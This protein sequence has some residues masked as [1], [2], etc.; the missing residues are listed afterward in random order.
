[1]PAQGAEV[2]KAVVAALVSKAGVVCVFADVT[3]N[4]VVDLTDLVDVA[5]HWRL[6]PGEAGNGGY[7]LNHDARMDIVDIQIV[8]MS[9]S[10]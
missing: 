3:C 7:D 6:D 2:I 9:F 8:A 5:N 4:G 10:Q 1:M